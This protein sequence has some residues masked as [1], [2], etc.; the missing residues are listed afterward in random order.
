MFKYPKITNHGTYVFQTLKNLGFSVGI[1]SDVLYHNKTIYYLQRLNFYSI[2][3]VP[4]N[5]SL[6]TVNFAIPTANDNL[7]SQAF[8]VRLLLRVRLTAAHQSRSNY[9]NL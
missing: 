6:H 4:V 3:L 2:G 1:V 8:F 9:H 7:F 5:Y